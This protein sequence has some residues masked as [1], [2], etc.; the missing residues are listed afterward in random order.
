MSAVRRPMTE[1][2]LASRNRPGLETLRSSDQ[3]PI[4]SSDREDV[5]PAPLDGLMRDP[6]TWALM[7]Q[8][9]P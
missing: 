9:V 3:A 4:Y 1:P 7:A 8:C 5:K 2:P 6:A